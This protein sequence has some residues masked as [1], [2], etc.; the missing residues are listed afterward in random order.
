M[1]YPYLD[2]GVDQ[3]ERRHHQIRFTTLTLTLIL[4]LTLTLTL[5]LKL[6]PQP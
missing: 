3:A 2:R 5:N 4:I 6:K 1:N